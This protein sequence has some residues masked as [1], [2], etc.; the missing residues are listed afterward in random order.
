MVKCNKN[1]I[2]SVGGRCAVKQCG[3]AISRTGR[4]LSKTPEVAAKHYE[5]AREAFEHYFG[6]GDGGHEC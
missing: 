1:C 5:M 2:A 6:E 3:G 4:C